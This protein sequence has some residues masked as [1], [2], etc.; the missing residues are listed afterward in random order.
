M[1][2]IPISS[3]FLSLKYNEIRTILTIAYVH[4]FL[5]L[6]IWDYV[7]RYQIIEAIR[8]FEEGALTRRRRFFDDRVSRVGAY[9]RVGAYSRGRLIEALRYLI[10]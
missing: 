10:W 6:H 5:I 9:L 4:M 7:I 2:H 1:L 3:H 8:L